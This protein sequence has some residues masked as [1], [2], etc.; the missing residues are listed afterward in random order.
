MGKKEF[1]IDSSNII[2]EVYHNKF[3]ISRLTKHVFRSAEKGDKVSKQLIQSA[4]E[5]LL[6]HFTPLKNRKCRIAL[7]G[8]LFSEE[9][10]LEKYLRN[11]AKIKFYNIEFV[12]PKLKPVW[13]AVKLAMSNINIQIDSKNERR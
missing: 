1:G 6:I 8:S 5:N 2:K 4:A 13:G 10:L 11:M 9:V 7:L 12:K 3:E